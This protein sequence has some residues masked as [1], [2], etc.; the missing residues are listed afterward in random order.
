[1]LDGDVSPIKTYGYISADTR[2]Q[3]KG[4]DTAQKS[5]KLIQ[6]MLIRAG[7][8][9][10]LDLDDFHSPIDCTRNHDR[11]GTA[12][13]SNTKPLLSHN[14]VYTSPLPHKKHPHLELF[15]GRRIYTASHDKPYL[16]RTIVPAAIA[17]IG[18]R[19][20]DMVLLI[21]SLLQSTNKWCTAPN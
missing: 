15:C 20:P 4:T 3:N 18:Y 16:D 10:R 11:M 6:I 9:A 8:W 19:C 13:Q 17:D 14:N 7:G 12:N 21:L 1:M 5:K 2:A